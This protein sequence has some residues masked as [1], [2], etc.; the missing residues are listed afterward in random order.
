[1]SFYAKYPANI[2]VGTGV[3]QVEGTGTPGVQAGGVLT[4]QGDPSGTPIPVSG[5]LTATNPSVGTTG[6]AV[7][8]SA[9]YVAATVAGTLTGLVATANGLKVD[10]TATTQPISGTVAATQSGTWTVQPGNMANTTAWK[11]DGSA[12]TQ[13]VSGTVTADAGTGTFAVSAV[14][15]PLP[16]GAATEASL[17]KLP[18]AQASTTSGQSGPL[19]QGAVTTSSPT[20]TTAQTSPLSLTTSG[21]LR[22][23]ADTDLVRVNGAGVNVGPGASAAGTQRVSVSSDSTIGLIAGTAIIGKVSIDQTTPG[24]TNGVQVNAALPAGTNKIGA[25]TTV[26][27]VTAVTTVSTVTAVT[28]VAAVTAI[29]NALPAGTN[30][31][32]SVIATATAA[33][34]WQAE[35]S[36]VAASVTNAYATILTPSAATKAVFLRNG[37]NQPIGFSFDAGSTTNVVLDSGDQMAIDYTPTGVISSTSAIQIKYTGSAPTTG[38][39][40][41]NAYH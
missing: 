40:R 41:V 18:V 30:A 10:G 31:I 36:I 5:S 15:L 23:T 7:P 8:A 19:M 37:T 25:L 14:S 22:V 12:V 6:T 24:T 28:T 13:P 26:D 21:Q 1:M 39:V 4:V 9:T 27:T 35:G 16:T 20:Y 33:A 3:S 38:T 29:T 17:V 32:G 2:A 11:V 34:V